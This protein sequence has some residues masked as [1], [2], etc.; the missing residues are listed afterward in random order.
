ML[1]CVILC[2]PI[3]ISIKISFYNDRKRDA[4]LCPSLL[5]KNQMWKETFVP[6]KMQTPFIIPFIAETGME[7]KVF[8]TVAF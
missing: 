1:C 6:I 7:L 4:S 8:K 5:C 2:P 3:S